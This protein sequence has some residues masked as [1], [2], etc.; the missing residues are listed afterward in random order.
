MDEA[1]AAR[2]PFFPGRV[3]HGYLLL[4]FAAGSFVQPDEGP[5]LANSG[6]DRLRFIKP[7]VPGSSITVQVTVKQKTPRNEE[8][9]EVRWQVMLD[10]QEGDRVAEYELLTM[11]A[12]AQR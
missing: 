4:S 10:D 11:N 1:A 5:L 8:Y 3:A 12:Y 6:L 9:G 2:N 7:L